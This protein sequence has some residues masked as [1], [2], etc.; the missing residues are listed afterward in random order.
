MPRFARI[1]VAGGLFHVICRFH[2][3][4]FYLDID[5]A[6][7]KYLD[8]LAGAAKSHDCRIVAYC[9]MSSHVHLLL[10][11][12]N[13]S[14]GKLTKSVNSPFATWVNDQRT[15]LGGVFADRP[16][17]VLAHT[18]TYGMELIRYIHNNPVRGGV[19]NR[20]GDSAWSSHRAYMGLAPVPEWLATEAVFG[21]DAS[22]HA[23]IRTELGKFVDEG[24]GEGRRPEFSG[25]VAPGLAKRVRRLMGGDVTLSY[26]VLGPDGFLVKVL[27][28]QAG[29]HQGRKRAQTRVTSVG[30][31][32]KAVFT[33]LGLDPA[34]A[35][36]RVKP[37]E[38]ARGRALVAW[39]WTEKMG[40][41]QVSV[42]D[43]L[44]LRPASITK[45]L[46]KLR[47]NGLTRADKRVVN[48]VFKS[49]LES[50]P[51]SSKPEKTPGTS[52]NR[53]L[54]EPKILVMKKQR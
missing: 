35:T 42:A 4:R 32:V 29:L 53:S 43:A 37:A 8:Y 20:A 11:L 15:G 25:E 1:H 52:S 54:R 7:E 14:L 24:R 6:R 23:R 48:K 46:T 5:G 3:R 10:Q 41:P 16:K 40:R 47:S 45:M 34:L 19:V 2:D 28:Q 17:S 50:E 51:E 18:D 44:N 22:E 39:L 30:P 38:V 9:L 26:P 12:G 21:G 31:I 49:L 27:E 36:K 33:E 13:D